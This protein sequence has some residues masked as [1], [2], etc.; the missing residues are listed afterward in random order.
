MHIGDLFEKNL[1][2]FKIVTMSEVLPEKLHKLGEH[3]VGRHVLIFISDYTTEN[4]LPFKGILESKWKVHYFHLDLKD[5]FHST[6]KK[7]ANSLNY[8]HYADSLVFDFPAFLFFLKNIERIRQAHEVIRKIVIFNPFASEL[9]MME[10]LG[11]YFL[12]KKYTN[13]IGKNIEIPQLFF[14]KFSNILEKLYFVHAHEVVVIGLENKSIALKFA[15]R[16]KNS[17]LETAS[18]YSEA[19][20]LLLKEFS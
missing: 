15:A 20:E 10:K 9:S 1:R 7:L 14:Q 4:H 6:S 12:K 18:T 5:D 2:E 3:G 16:M 17:S 8:Y 13:L 11:R 19:T